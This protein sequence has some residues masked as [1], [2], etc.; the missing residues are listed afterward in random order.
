MGFLMASF[1]MFMLGIVFLFDRALIVMGNMAFL[2]GLV[3]LIGGKSTLGFF[4][5]KGILTS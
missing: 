5:K 3:L 1:G 2:V 4:I